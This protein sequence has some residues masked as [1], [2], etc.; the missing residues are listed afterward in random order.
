MSFTAN[1]DYV[2]EPEPVECE[3]C[4]GSGQVVVG[5]GRGKRTETCGECFGEGVR[6]VED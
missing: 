4:D 6:E 1:G 5:W 2:P 3:A